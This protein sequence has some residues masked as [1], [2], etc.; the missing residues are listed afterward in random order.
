MF[1]VI[2][3]QTAAERAKAQQGEV[4]RQ[5]EAGR[6]VRAEAATHRHEGLVQVDVVLVRLGHLRGAATRAPRPARVQRKVM[7]FTD[8]CRNTS[9]RMRVN[10]EYRAR[11]MS[12]GDEFKAAAVRGW[13]VWRMPREKSVHGQLRARGVALTIKHCGGH[14]V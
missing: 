6:T 3:E 14:A 8:A 7:T 1:F 9:G 5:C 2:A 12:T 13:Y 11:E 4:L 10:G